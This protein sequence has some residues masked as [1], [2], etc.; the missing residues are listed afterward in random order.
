MTFNTQLRVEC[1]SSF[2][3]VL[4]RLNVRAQLASR[5]ILCLAEVNDFHS[6]GLLKM[7][8]QHDIFQ[9]EVCMYYPNSLQVAECTGELK[10]FEVLK[11]IISRP[12]VSAEREA[13]GPYL[14]DNGPDLVQMKRLGIPLLQ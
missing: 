3:P 11:Y 2:S 4:T 13:V 1:G 10:S 9:L 6:V 7:V 14:L 8:D 5:H 12:I